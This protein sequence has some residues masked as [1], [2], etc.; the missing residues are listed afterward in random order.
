MNKLYLVS[1]FVLIGY[2]GSAQ[3]KT[4]NIVIVTLDGMRWQELFGGADSVLLRNSNI[5]KTDKIPLNFFGR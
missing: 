4:E 5:P 3:S 1:L 2:L